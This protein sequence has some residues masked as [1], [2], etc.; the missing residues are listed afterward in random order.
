MSL[1]NYQVQIITVFLI[2]AFSIT[3]LYIKGLFIKALSIKALSIKAFGRRG[4][5]LRLA[6]LC[7]QGRQPARTTGLA[8][9]D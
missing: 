9:S 1:E 4:S 3:A 2:T 8:S 7:V 5:P 6:T